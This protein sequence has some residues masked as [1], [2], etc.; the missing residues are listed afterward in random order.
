MRILSIIFALLIGASAVFADDEVPPIVEKYAK[1]FGDVN[2][3]SAPKLSPSGNRMAYFYNTEDDQ[4][5]VTREFVDGKL[6]KM[7][8]M[9]AG[10]NNYFRWI[11]WANEDRILFSFFIPGEITSR[12][13]VFDSTILMATDFDGQNTQ[14]I[15]GQE[16]RK[17]LHSVSQIR[18]MRFRNDN[19]ISLLPNDPDHILVGHNAGGRKQNDIYKVNINTGEK[20][21]VTEAPNRSIVNAWLADSNGDVRVG[22]S[23]NRGE[24]EVSLMVRTDANG[25]WQRLQNKKMFEDGRFNIHAFTED[26]KF[27]YVT[28][29]FQ[30]GRRALYKFNIETGELGEEVFAHDVVDI[31]GVRLNRT[32]GKPV[33]ITYLNHQ[34]ETIFL[35]AELSAAFAKI[36]ASLKAP[37][38]L[39]SMSEDRTKAVIMESS[40]QIA[41]TYYYVDLKA[42]TITSLFRRYKDAVSERNF[43]MQPISYMARD[44]QEITGYITYPESETHG[45]SNLPLIVMPHD[46]PVARDY[47]S[48]DWQ[49][50][51]LANLGYAVF[52]PNYRGSSGYGQEFI[53]KGEGEWGDKI[54]K[55]VL[56]GVEHLVDEG[57]VDANRVCIMGEYFGGYLALWGATQMSDTYRCAISFGGV[58]DIRAYLREYGAF[59]KGT[60]MYYDILG[61]RKKSQA[62]V[63]SPVTYAENLKTPVL[64]GHLSEDSAVDYDRQAKEFY[65]EAKDSDAAVTLVTLDEGGTGIAYKKNRIYWLRQLG[66]FLLQHNPPGILKTEVDTAAASEPLDTTSQNGSS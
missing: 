1:I 29:D 60:D 13:V 36:T 49:V 61:T 37:Y 53:A 27:I 6:K 39:I 24:D 64:L 19:L 51:F 11:E 66:D 3:R 38:E 14:L 35:D 34:E 44:A 30:T 63:W 16:G 10:D 42:E 18:E 40:P 56:D 25:K 59:K 15:L 21:I 55:D 43:D 26:P 41:G 54:P 23:A 28:S 52:Q 45:R 12:R 57:L 4:F 22:L 5:L 31:D 32:S 50:Q 2:N 20:W 47:L 46:G 7:M 48:W 58:A 62:R 8:V 9:P 33:A 65:D 17:R